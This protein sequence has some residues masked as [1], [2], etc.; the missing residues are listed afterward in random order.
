M[1]S[2]FSQ[3]VR[4]RFRQQAQGRDDLSINMLELLAM[5]VGAWVFIVRSEM[6]PE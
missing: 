1:A 2:D 6:R 4:E 3:E 5:V